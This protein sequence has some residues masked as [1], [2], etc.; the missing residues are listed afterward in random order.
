MLFSVVILSYNSSRTLS[1][2][3]SVLQKTL[4]QYQEPSEVLVVENGSRDKSVD[5]LSDF[6][7]RY[8][9]LIKPIILRR[10]GVSNASSCSSS[11]INFTYALQRSTGS[12]SF[13]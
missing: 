1:R 3:L 13:K 2:C 12:G 7:A 5:I 9:E 6:E 10:S 8:P 4:S 11:S